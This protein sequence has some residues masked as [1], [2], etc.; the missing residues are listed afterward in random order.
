MI[1]TNVKSEGATG[2]RA[3]VPCCEVEGFI[4][5]DVSVFQEEVECK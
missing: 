5:G 2:T 1:R 3:G 4:P